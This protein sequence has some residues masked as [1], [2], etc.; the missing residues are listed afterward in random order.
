[1]ERDEWYRLGVTNGWIGPSLCVLHDGL[2]TTAEEDQAMEVGDDPCVFMARFY[3]DEHEKAAVQANHA[4][5]VWRA[6]NDG[7]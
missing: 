6:T 4:P 2:P 7:L 1:M 5:S 3:G